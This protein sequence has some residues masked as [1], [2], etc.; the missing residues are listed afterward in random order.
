MRHDETAPTA[1]L[2]PSL[3]AGRLA[4]GRFV[5]TLSVK[6]ERPSREEE[7]HIGN[8]LASLRRER[9]L[10]RTVLAEQLQIHPTTLSALENGT[11]APS[12]RLALRVS[13]VFGLPIEAIFFAP[14]REHLA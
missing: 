1:H 8:R 13:E 3:W 5:L 14:T 6:R 11:Y 2:R 9:G 7:E 4:L 10:S 12:L